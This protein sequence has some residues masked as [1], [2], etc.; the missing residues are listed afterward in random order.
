MQVLW[1]TQEFFRRTSTTVVQGQAE[2]NSSAVL[3]ATPVG[4]NIKTPL[5]PSIAVTLW[6][7][8]ESWLLVVYVHTAL[9]KPQI[10]KEA[11]MPSNR[12]HHYT[13]LLE[14]NLLNF[15]PLK[16]LPCKAGKLSSTPH[17]WWALT[18]LSEVTPASRQRVS[19]SAAALLPITH[20]RAEYPGPEEQVT[21]RFKLKGESYSILSSWIRLFLFPLFWTVAARRAAVPQEFRESKSPSPAV[22]AKRGSPV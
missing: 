2:L 18:R 21:A 10:Q 22:I 14:D 20:W 5:L 16:T 7:E 1:S 19:F 4:K 6:G 11:K 9:A 12:F 17:Y 3:W 8:K 15:W 13:A